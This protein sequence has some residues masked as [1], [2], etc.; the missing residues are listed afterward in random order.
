MSKKKDKRVESLV[1]Y[2]AQLYGV[3]PVRLMNLL[4]IG[5]ETP[6][7]D[8]WVQTLAMACPKEKAEDKVSDWI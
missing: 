4:A 5:G 3:S 1:G 7:L 6:T 8:R 2:Y